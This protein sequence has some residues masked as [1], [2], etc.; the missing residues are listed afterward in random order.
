MPVDLRPPE[1]ARRLGNKFGLIY[2]SLPIYIH[3]P[4]ERLEEVKRR[5]DDIKST[6]EAFVAYQI[7]N[8]LGMTPQQISDRFIDMFGAKAT[9]VMT[10]VRGPAQAIYFAGGK[11]ETLMFW[12]PQSGRMAMGVSIFSYDNAVVLGIATDAALVPDP[13]TI[14]DCFEQEFRDMLEWVRV[15]ALTKK[16]PPRS[17]EAPPPSA[18]GSARRCAG[19]A[20]GS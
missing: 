7:L 10:N 1:E 19:P 2:L 18:A 13:E 12:V 3:D 4:I 17:L 9:A 14:N 6:P 11:A 15:Q 20:T 8:A 16:S 5:M